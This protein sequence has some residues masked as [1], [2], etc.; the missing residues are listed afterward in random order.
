MHRRNRRLVTG[1]DRHHGHGHSQRADL[2]FPGIALHRATRTVPVLQIERTA[3]QRLIRIVS[4]DR[5][6]GR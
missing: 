6:A 2:S 4:R 1:I 5:E 3:G